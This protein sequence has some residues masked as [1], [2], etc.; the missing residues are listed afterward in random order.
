MPPKA[1][2]PGKAKSHSLLVFS[3]PEKEAHEASDD[4][5]VPDWPFRMLLCGPP[6]SGKRSTLL[7]ILSHLEQ[8]PD[9]TSVLHLDPETIEYADLSPAIYGPDDPPNFEDFDRGERN[10]LIVDEVDINSLKKQAQSD[11]ERL[12]GHGSTHR[13]TSIALCFQT[14]H[15]I[16]PAIR[17]ACQ[18]YILFKSCDKSELAQIALRAG[19]PKEDL[20]EMMGHILKD[21]H[22]SL[23][24]DLTK[25]PDSPLRFRLN[26][27][28][29]IT[30][31]L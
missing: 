25:A 23:W 24:I 17:R 16:P 8:W 6:N 11:V 7:C 2:A 5:L 30:R 15:K 22:D 4:P 13:N 31:R 12:F 14:F 29:P 28:T 3:N 9:K 10:L 21:P 27:W 19:V 26:L 18:H 20:L 1:R